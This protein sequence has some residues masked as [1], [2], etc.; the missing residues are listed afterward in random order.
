MPPTNTGEREVQPVVSTVRFD[1]SYPSSVSSFHHCTDHI[2]EIIM[3]NIMEKTE[4]RTRTY[5]IVLGSC[6]YHLFAFNNLI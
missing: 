1:K 3:R 5:D 2:I 6:S 4:S